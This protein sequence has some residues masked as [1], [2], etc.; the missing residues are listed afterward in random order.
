[1]KRLLACLVLAALVGPAAA[2]LNDREL[3]SH[4]R[5]F[6]SQ[7]NRQTP[8]MPPSSGSTYPGGF[9]L[10]IGGGSVL[11]IGAFGLALTGPRARK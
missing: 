7:Y 10:L 1:M 8:P 5:E 4:E 3:P 9:P 6:R 2:C 11:L